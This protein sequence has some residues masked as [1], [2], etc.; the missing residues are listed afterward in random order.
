MMVHLIVQ[1]DLVGRQPYPNHTRKHS[2][3]NNHTHHMFHPL[4]SLM[5]RNHSK[6]HLSVASSE[7]SAMNGTEIDTHYIPSQTS[8]MNGTEIDTHHILAPVPV[9]PKRYSDCYNSQSHLCPEFPAEPHPSSTAIHSATSQQLHAGPQHPPRPKVGGYGEPGMLQPAVMYGPQDQMGMNLQ[10]QYGNRNVYNV[11]GNQITD[12][13]GSSVYNGEHGRMSYGTS[14]V[15]NSTSRKKIF[16]NNSSASR[17]NKE[18]VPVISSGKPELTQPC[19]L[20]KQFRVI[21]GGSMRVPSYSKLP[22]GGEGHEIPT[23]LACYCKEGE[24]DEVGGAYNP[25]TRMLSLSP[26]HPAMAGYRNTHSL[27]DNMPHPLF[28]E[29]V[30]PTDSRETVAVDWEV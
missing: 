19:D 21:G 17:A 11:H 24:Q 14:T 6:S 5:L 7:T 3:Q 16:R 12:E 8:A 29:V 2:H 26:Y 9:K 23:S 27:H 28:E 25:F 22:T 4:N 10:V 18:D 15:L 1:R 30:T 13:F 20:S